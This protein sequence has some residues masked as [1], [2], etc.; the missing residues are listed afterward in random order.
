MTQLFFLSSPGSD[1]GIQYFIVNDRSLDIP[2]RE[3]CVWS[4]ISHTY[5]LLMAVC[6]DSVTVLQ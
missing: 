5:V 2:I 3:V 1:R 6:F 4:C